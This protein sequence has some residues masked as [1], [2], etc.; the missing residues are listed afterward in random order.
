MNL[1][2][3]SVLYDLI[4]EENVELLTNSFV[5]DLTLYELGNVAWKQYAK[6]KKISKNE[7]EVLI[8]RMGELPFKLIRIE[9]NEITEIG[10]QA[11]EHNLTLYDAA[12]FHYAHKYNLELLTSDGSLK[13]AWKKKK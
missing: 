3:T 10:L 1:I 7:Y 8:K 2:D 4:V 5:L 13:E 6:L 12:Y 9:P 11:A